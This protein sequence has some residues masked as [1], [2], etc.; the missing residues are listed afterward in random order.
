[1]WQ[2]I[3]AWPR[4]SMVDTTLVFTA[5]TGHNAGESSR[6]PVTGTFMIT[7]GM[8]QSTIQRR[9]RLDE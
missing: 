7:T 1:M 4:K 8:D 6:F 9:H 5:F 3:E 2:K